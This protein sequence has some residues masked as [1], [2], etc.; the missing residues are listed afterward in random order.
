MQPAVVTIIV[1]EGTG[2]IF[3]QTLTKRFVIDKSIQYYY[4]ENNIALLL[5][6]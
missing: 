2:E 5:F 4:T 1:V 6:M 3:R